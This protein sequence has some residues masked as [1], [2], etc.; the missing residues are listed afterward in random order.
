MLR[1]YGV[2]G[3]GGGGSTLHFVFEA[4]CAGLLRCRATVEPDGVGVP[5]GGCVLVGECVY[6]VKEQRDSPCDRL[7]WSGT[8]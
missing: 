6:I 8:W 4:I 7:Q 3:G 2:G 5:I 1:V